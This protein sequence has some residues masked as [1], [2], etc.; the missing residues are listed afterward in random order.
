[1]YLSTA[2]I[3]RET[4]VTIDRTIKELEGRS[5]LG[6]PRKRGMR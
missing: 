4:R 2:V 1:L 6:V 5:A 3:I